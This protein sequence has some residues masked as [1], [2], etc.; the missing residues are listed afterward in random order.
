MLLATV[1]A[2]AVTATDAA[3]I[4]TSPRFASLQGGETLGA[5]SADL[6]FTAGFPAISATY[7]QALSDSAD[8]GALV[9]LDWL[10][11]E[12]IVGGVYRGLLGRSGSVTFGWHAR[13][14]VY[15]NLGATWAYSQNREGT[16]LQLM[17]GVA[18]SVR[19]ARG[20]FSAAVDVPMNATFWLASGFA[21]GVRGTLAYE[22]PLWGDLLV[23][24]RGGVG[25]LISSSGAPFGLDSPRLTTELVALLTYRIF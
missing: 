16:G 18:L 21:V 19:G 11:T 22:T 15:A 6:V 25:T 1:L 2:L 23:G 14:G 12:L 9:E 10:S 13:A 4:P 5:G 24:A 7:A 17:P 8:L 20:V 3:S